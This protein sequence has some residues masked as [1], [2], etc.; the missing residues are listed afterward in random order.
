MAPYGI[1]VDVNCIRRLPAFDKNCSS[2]AAQIWY[3]APTALARRAIYRPGEVE[4]PRGLL[5]SIP[6]ALK[7]SDAET[8]GGRPASAYPL[9]RAPEESRAAALLHRGCMWR[10]KCL[11]TASRSPAAGRAG[12]S[13]GRSRGFATTLTPTHTAFR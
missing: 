7:A 9:A 11:G 8:L 10:G 4:Q 5:V 6:Y 2:F 3:D 13:P 12:E 1:D